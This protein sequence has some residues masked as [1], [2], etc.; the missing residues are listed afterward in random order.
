MKKIIA[1]SIC[2]LTISISASAQDVLSVDEMNSVYKKEQVLNKNVRQ[3]T[4]LREAD[5]MWSRK[6]WREID[7]REKINHPFYYPENDGVGFT[8]NDRKSLIDV[9]YSAIKEG[10]ITAY[11]NA[12][13]DD[14]FREPMSQDEIKS[15]GGAKEEL[16]EVIDWDAV[17]A[18]ADP[19]DAKTTILETSQFDRN[20]VKKWRLKEEW[21][22]DKQK[23]TM[24]V[25]ILGI[26]PLQE[27]RDQVNGRLTGSF[28]PL[29]WVYF[30]EAREVLIN[31]EVFNSVKNDAERRTYDDVFWKRMFNST[32]TME[33]NV[34]NRRINE[35]MVG[36]DALLEAERIKA[37]IFNIEHDL[38]EY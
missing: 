28:S 23:S 32:I 36:L 27:D 25:R 1:I 29:F 12:A 6:V 30:P 34:M 5:V 33:A 7:L 21:F 2:F 24:D 10:S 19:E 17:A 31:A 16:I 3:Y 22:F 35:Y 20:S 37:D 26:A 13:M 18:G 9:I 38:W 14:E 15:I 4:H 11:G 8:T